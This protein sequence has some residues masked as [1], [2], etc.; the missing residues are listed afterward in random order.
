LGLG[1]DALRKIPADR[2]YRM[3]VKLLEKA[4]ADDKA[5]GL[6]PFCVIGTAG[7]V[8]TAATDPLQ[9]IAAI[10]KKE[11]LWFHLDG[12]YGVLAA[13]TEKYAHLVA[14]Y[15]L[16]DSVAFDLH[17]WMYM[18]YEIGCVLIKDRTLQQDAFAI[19]PSYLSTIPGGVG[20]EPMHFYNKGIEL[21]RSFRALKVW[22]SLKIHGAKQFIT[23]IERNINQAQYLS[24]RVQQ[25]PKLELLAPTELN[26]VCFRYI[27][28]HVKQ[29]D[30]NQLNQ[31]ILI[32]VQERGIAVPS[33]TYLNGQ[34]AIRVSIT[35]Q[36]SQKE[37]FDVFLDEILAI[38]QELDNE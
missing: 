15:E 17:K 32:A 8:G 30:L 5:A 11:D 28:E 4:I 24:V 1:A 34:F 9:E 19:T 33:H 26:I 23:L 38:G 35:N 7:T 36:R 29:K 13:V 6:K 12:A 16:A 27:G 31:D 14:G 20:A 22:F 21:T 25:H 37:D 10:C 18:P 3:D 2:N